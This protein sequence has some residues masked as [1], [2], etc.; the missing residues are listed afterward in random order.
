MLSRN[1]TN[2]F[3]SH[4]VEYRKAPA[5]WATDLVVYN[6]SCDNSISL[7]FEFAPEEYHFEVYEVTV[8][9][10]GSEYEIHRALIHQVC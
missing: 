8:F 10:N 9:L 1:F 5:F 4:V 6:N 2:C 3:Y 7:T